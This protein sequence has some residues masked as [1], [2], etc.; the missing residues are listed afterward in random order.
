MTPRRLLRRLLALFDAR[1]LDDELD[2]EIAA[3]L[4]LAERDARA[5]GLSPVEARREARRRFGGVEAMKDEHRDTRGVRWLDTVAR[6]ARYGAGA[7]RREPTFAAI[8]IG[9]LALGIGA[10]AATFTLFSAV[11]LKPMPFDDPDRI[12]QVWEAPRPGVSNATTTLDFLD[13]QRLGTAFEA[14][15]AEDSGAMALETGGDPVRLAAKRVTVDYFRVFATRPALGRF[16]GEPDGRP[17]ADPVVILSHATWR[18]FFGASP[19]VLR[20]RALLDGRPHQIIG[21]LPAGVFEQDET[22]VY[23]PL[24][25]TPEQSSREIHWLTVSARLGPGVTRERA[26]DQLRAIRAAQPEVTPVFKREWTIEV[27]PLSQLLVDDTLRR[28]L[29]VACG[30]VLLVLLIACANVANLLLARGATRTKELAIRIAIGA[31]RGRVVAQ[32][33]IEGAVL[34]LLGGAAGLL[35]AWWIV[36]AATPALRGL[37]P[38]SAVVSLDWRVLLF[39]LAVTFATV[40]LSALFPAWHASVRG[41]TAAAAG[42]GRGPSAPRA[43]LR[44]AIVAAEVAMSVVLLCGALLLAQSLGNLLRID[45]GVRLDGLVTMSLDLPARTY[46][47]RERA[48][49]FTEALADGLASAPGVSRASL[50][51]FLPMRWVAN[52]EVLWLP[53]V[54]RPVRVRFKR[55]AGD[56]FDTLDIPLIAGRGITRGD[57][58][59]GPPI[60]VVNQTLAAQIV[61]AA[62]VPRP[63][64]LT[65]RLQYVTFGQAVDTFAEIVGVIQSERTGNP[66]VPDPPVLYVPLTQAPDPRLKLIVRSDASPAAALGAVRGVLRAVDPGIPVADVMTMREVHDRTYR[67][68]SRPAWTFGMFAAIAILLST[69]GLYGVLSQSVAQQRREL[70]VRLALGAAPADLV[71]RTVAG[72]LRLV[73]IGAIAGLGGA[74]AFAPV[75][76]GLLYGVSAL[77]P[78]VLAAAVAGIVTTGLAA[79]AFPARRAARVEPALVLRDDA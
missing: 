22:A 21:V 76:R 55:V 40:L 20:E 1:R 67:G 26:R 63:V 73:G 75:L 7:L 47:S 72:A 15:A 18:T 38:P 49:Q 48:A 70:A 61:T 71:R 78:R 9:V 17:G 46:P 5:A 44:K 31:G 19:G 11:L 23:T 27:E 4:E 34:C 69:L 56:Y 50:T 35:L 51:T 2:A 64:G 36:T 30:A 28:T 43:Y 10:N 3:H 6:D 39:T 77:D 79:A 42:L 53:G 59:G 32:L 60:A 52:G 16:F 66:R 74:L 37:L 12:V 41:M 65:V 58:A 25:F 68:A 14:V 54:E 29:I 13:W 57:R 33:V 8:V 45:P 24:V 62:R